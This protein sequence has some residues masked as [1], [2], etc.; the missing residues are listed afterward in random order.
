MIV[1][2]MDLVK[3]IF[4][5]KSLTNTHHIHSYTYIQ[6]TM[7]YKH[8]NASTNFSII[9]FAILLQCRRGCITWIPLHRRACPPC[10]EYC[11]QTFFSHL[12]LQ[13]LPP[14]QKPL[15]PRPHHILLRFSPFHLTSTSL[16]EVSRS[17]CACT[18]AQFLRFTNPPFSPP[19]HRCWS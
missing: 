16:Y 13:G 1:S 18:A 2:K 14:L 7:E 6:P 4:A 19:F 17:C 15:Y 8:L 11:R 5:E 10:W 3:S 9:C 12:P